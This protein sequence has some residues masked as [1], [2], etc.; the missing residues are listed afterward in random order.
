M[1]A[2][3]SESCFTR[4]SRCNPRRRF[5]SSLCAT[6]FTHPNTI[7]LVITYITYPSIA[8]VAPLPRAVL[9]HALFYNH[10]KNIYT[11]RRMHRVFI[12][13]SFFFFA[14]FSFFL[15]CGEKCDDVCTAGAAPAHAHHTHESEPP[16]GGI[17]ASVKLKIGERPRRDEGICAVVGTVQNNIITRLLYRN[18]L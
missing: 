2:T 3:M 9:Q 7:L 4:V 1:H 6:I 14:F 16:G 8:R 18:I 5:S 15:F 17:T 10:N 12:I 13:I 11:V